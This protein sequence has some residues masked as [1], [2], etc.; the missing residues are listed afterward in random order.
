MIR[1]FIIATIILIGVYF[2]SNIAS[3]T[4]D[5]KRKRLITLIT[6]ILI[7]QSGLRNLGVG[8][9]TYQYYVRFQNVQTTPWSSVLQS[10]IHWEGKDSFYGLFQKVFQAFSGN[11]TIYLITVALIFMPA[12][13]IFVY[14]NTSRVSHTVLAYIIYM[15][16][17]YGFFSITGI[18]QTLATAF[19]LY[20]FE[21][22]KKKKAI[23]FIF[24]VLFASLFHITALVFLP[25]Y[26]IGRVKWTKTLFLLVVICFPILMMFKNQLAVFFVSISDLQ[27]RFGTYTS[28]YKT[29]SFILTAFQILLAI[30]ALFYIDRVKA[31]TPNARLMYNTFAMALFFLPL[32]WVNPSA[33]RISQYFGVIMMVWVPYLIDA[34][35]IGSVKLRRSFYVFASVLFIYITTYSI[36]LGTYKFFWQPMKLPFGY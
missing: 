31:M 16:Y 18:R 29:G 12:L 13:G 4:Q 34:V 6:L 19:L 28:Q 22:I 9:D 23:L 27:D 11:Y 8:P 1:L 14:K 15:G 10:F 3:G 30:W 25:L 20:S 36:T 2:S 5:K 32:Q 35:S 24:L 7:L 26:F 21:C 17:F 33:G